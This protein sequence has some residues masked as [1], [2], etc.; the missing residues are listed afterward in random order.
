MHPTGSELVKR[1]IN[2]LPTS[3][4]CSVNMESC[5]RLFVGYPVAQNL[6]FS[7]LGLRVDMRN[8]NSLPQ[9]LK[10]PVWWND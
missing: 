10:L 6:W 1:K 2:V 7:E 5:L 4:F 9:L 3:I 8:V